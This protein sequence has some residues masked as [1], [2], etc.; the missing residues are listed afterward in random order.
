LG[1]I[2]PKLLDVKAKANVPVRFHVRIE[3][4]DGEQVPPENVTNEFNKLLKDI[5]GELRLE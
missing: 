5:K 2:M 4:G 1:D 3:V